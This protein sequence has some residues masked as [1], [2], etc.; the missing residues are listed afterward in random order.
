MKIHVVETRDLIAASPDGA[1]VAPTPLV[2]AAGVHAL[3]LNLAAGQSVGPCDM[4]I[5][6]LY[7]VI[8]GQGRVRVGDE[9]AELQAGSLTVVPA[10]AVRALSATEPMRVLAVQVL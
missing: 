3:L 4:P 2:N 9:Q 10:G 8:A 5:T 7:Y 6:V 1:A